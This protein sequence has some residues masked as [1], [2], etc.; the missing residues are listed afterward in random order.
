[1]LNFGH[2]FFVC[3]NNIYFAGFSPR[4]GSRG[5]G[6]FGGGRGKY[7]IFCCQ[8]TCILAHIIQ[9]DVIIWLL[10][11][12]LYCYICK[13]LIKKGFD[14]FCLSSCVQLDAM[15]TFENIFKCNYFVFLQIQ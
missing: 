1:M 2:V 11:V 8:N 10:S 5:R 13:F 15:H 12:T 4:G 9:A 14:I 6:G 3:K 7:F